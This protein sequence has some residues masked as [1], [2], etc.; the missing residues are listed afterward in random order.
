MD[1][2]YNVF[3]TAE[4][5]RVSVEAVRKWCIEFEA[6]LS[7]SANPGQGKTRTLNQD[8]LEVMAFVAERR[9][10]GASYNEIHVDLQ[11]GQRG[12]IPEKPDPQSSMIQTIEHINRI[13]AE[14]DLLYDQVTE[15]KQRLLLLE[16]DREE[17]IRAQALL[18]MERARAEKA[19][20]TIQH[21]ITERRELDREIARLQI[22]LEHNQAANKLNGD[23]S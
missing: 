9:A 1:N 13:L 8:D 3:A 15:Y 6:Y 19:E 21:L 23:K 17:N 4:L 2:Y 22:L 14:N 11:N 5:F 20:Q 16:K 12:T 18:E 7:P 10:A